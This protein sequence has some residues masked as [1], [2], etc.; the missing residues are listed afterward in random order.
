[1]DAGDRMTFLERAKS[2]V[3]HAATSFVI[4]KFFIERENE[5]FRK[6]FGPDFPD[7]GDLAKSAPLVFVSSNELY[8]LPRPTLSKIL[9]IGGIGMKPQEAKPLPPNV[10]EKVDHMDNIIIF[11][12]GSVANASLMSIEWKK[13]FMEAFAEFPR[14][15]FFMRYPIDD[16]NGFKPKN[17]ELMSW[18]PQMDL[19]SKSLTFI[20]YPSVNIITFRSSQSQGVYYSCWI[21]LS[22]GSY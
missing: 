1:M 5:V 20:I 4:K 22:P 12:L 16:M 15:Q 11:S 10:Q 13:A 6:A 7:L 8:D 17:V 3:G 14:T 21:Q 18:I 19:L 2:I 9:Y